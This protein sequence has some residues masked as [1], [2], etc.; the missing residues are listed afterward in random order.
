MVYRPPLGGALIF[1]SSISFSPVDSMEKSGTEPVPVEVPAADARE[2][3]GGGVV[4]PPEKK[5]CG[6]CPM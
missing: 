4:H 5:V 6:P 2:A 1:R 3:D